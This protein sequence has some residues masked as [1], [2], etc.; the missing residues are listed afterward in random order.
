M[1]DDD[2][3]ALPLHGNG[4]ARTPQ[5]IT[6]STAFLGCASAQQPALPRFA[7]YVPRV[8]QAVSPSTRRVYSTYWNRVI[9]EWGPL[10][11]TAVTPLEIIEHAEQ[12]KLTVVKRRN[13]RGGR[14]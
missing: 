3:H 1:N 8:A 12:V 6:T 4:A 2:Q 9:A 14:V 11:I 13:A 5:K 7:D 10:P